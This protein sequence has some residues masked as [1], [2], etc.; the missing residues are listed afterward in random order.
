[1]EATRVVKDF[2][3]I[4]P[5]GICDYAISHKNKA[6]Q[7]YAAL[8]AAA[9]AKDLF[10]IV[11]SGN[12]NQPLDPKWLFHL[13]AI[14]LAPVGLRELCVGEIGFGGQGYIHGSAVAR[15][16]DS[17]DTQ[18]SQELRDQRRELSRAIENNSWRRPQGVL[19]AATETK[20]AK[21]MVDCDP[22]TARTL[23]HYPAMSGIWEPLPRLVEIGF[24]VDNG[25]SGW[26]TPLHLA[27]LR[28]HCKAT[29]V[30]VR[31]CHTKVHM[32][33]TQD[34]FL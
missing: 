18:T 17:H 27:V 21:F 20:L 15:P 3:S 25:D 10:S 11:P 2:P 5:R 26:Q 32:K 33:D 4:V 28:G 9:F 13:D 12:I 16:R 22:D 29:N 34:L 6:W 30:L 19:D 31:D 7:G 14:R 23:L 24:R 1:M 8:E